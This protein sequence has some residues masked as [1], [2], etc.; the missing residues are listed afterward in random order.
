MVDFVILQKLVCLYTSAYEYEDTNNVTVESMWQSP[1]VKKNNIQVWT[2]IDF[3]DQI[4]L[5]GQVQLWN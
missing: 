5:G 3:V 1:T 4:L 2:F